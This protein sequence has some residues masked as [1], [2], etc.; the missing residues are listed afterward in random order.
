VA[1]SPH[2]PA[3]APSG[4]SGLSNTEASLRLERFG[5]NAVPDPKPRLTRQF[6]GRFWGPVPWMLEAAALLELARGERLPAL[7]IASL[8][9]FNATLGLLRE[10]RASKAVAA[11]KQG[12]A[13]TAHVCREGIWSRV[14]AST[15]VPGD[16][17]RLSLGAIV[18]ADVRVVSGLVQVDQ[19]S[20]TGESLPVD[21]STGDSTFAGALVARGQALAEVAATGSRTF[22]GRAIELVAQTQGKTSEELAVMSA[23]CRLALN[24]GVVAILA[25]AYAVATKMSLPNTLDLALTILLASIPVALPATFTLASAI[26]ALRLARQG[27]LLTRLSAVHEAAALDTLC[28]D[29]TGTLTRNALQ[30]ARIVPSSGVESI[31]VLRMAAIATTSPGI[32]S[33]TTVR[34]HR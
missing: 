26:A 24:N 23:T 19:S 11:L 12:L 16:L 34:R 9:V 13:P 10:R 14:A 1:L 25:L 2:D 28:S 18:P 8:L 20:L 7:V 15:L 33:G 6:A 4:S 3:S 17:V 32:A 5:P 29:K 30:V 27:V 31:D 21:V 22:Y